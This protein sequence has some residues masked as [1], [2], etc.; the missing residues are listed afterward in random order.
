MKYIYFL[1]ILSY[2]IIISLEQN[3]ENICDLNHFCDNCTYCGTN[4]N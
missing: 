2:I 4:D 3:Q 1:I